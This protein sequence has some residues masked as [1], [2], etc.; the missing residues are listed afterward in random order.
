MQQSNETI[1]VDLNTLKEHYEKT[2]TERNKVETYGDMIDQKFVKEFLQ[3][4]I[5]TKF[6]HQIDFSQFCDLINNL[7]NGKAVGISDVSNEMLKYAKNQ[8]VYEHIKNIFETMINNQTILVF[9]L[10]SLFKT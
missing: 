6:D 8:K 3:L 5:N 9:D 7:P 10:N 1:N 2:F 4:H